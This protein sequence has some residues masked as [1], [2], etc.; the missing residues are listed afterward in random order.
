VE[1]DL[2]TLFPSWSH[3]DRDARDRLREAAKDAYSPMQVWDVI[4][5]RQDWFRIAQ[6]SIRRSDCVVLIL[7]VN[8]AASLHC[9]REVSF[10]HRLGIRTLIWAPMLDLSVAP[11][12]AGHARWLSSEAIDARRAATTILNIINE[13]TERPS[14]S[15]QGRPFET[16][17]H[18]SKRVAPTRGSRVPEPPPSV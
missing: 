14:Q 8:S 3:L 2:T 10:A 7:T 15:S 9:E 17:E 12:W 6:D 18:H 11:E 13:P 1:G 16:P 5:P 4:Q